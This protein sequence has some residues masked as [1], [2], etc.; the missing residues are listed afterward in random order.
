VKRLLAW[1]RLHAAEHGGDP[2]LLVLSGSSAGAHLT[3]MAASTA[4]DPQFQPGF[5]HVE[6]SIAAGVGFGGYYGPLGGDADSTSDPLAHAGPHCPPFMVVHGENDTST[7]I[8]G[9]RR[10]VAGLRRSSREPVVFAVLPG[11]QHSFDLFHSIR[12][13]HVVLGVTEFTDWL[14]ARTHQR[15]SSEV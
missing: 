1:I 9:A 2:D 13:S 5:E 15:A 3:A 8:D 7:P 14:Q 4:N 10:F 12:F 11:G 6:T